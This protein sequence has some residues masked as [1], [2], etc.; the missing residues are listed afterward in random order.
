MSRNASVALS[1]EVEAPGVELY[2][3]PGVVSQTSWTP[4]EG[5][6]FERWARSIRFGYRLR[7]AAMWWI[8]DGLNWGEE[9]F[10]EQYAQVMD[11]TDYE[12]STL[13]NAA[14]VA[15]RVAPQVRRVELSWSHHAEIAA[16]KDA[17]EQ[18]RWLTLAIEGSWTSK[19]LRERVAS[20]RAGDTQSA[21]GTAHEGHA[22][23]AGRTPPARP[24]LSD[25][26]ERASRQAFIEWVEE[27]GPK[28][29]LDHFGS[30]PD[31]REAVRGRLAQ[32]TSELV[33]SEW[34]ARA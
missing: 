10:G 3:L 5:L 2:G 28:G 20:A 32:R 21:S 24:D 6:D 18:A 12:Y 31:Y 16:C 8:G 11:A 4:P 27:D 19:E 15:R 17:D 34:T 26:V 1:S 9:R 22:T 13:A 25:L 14:S 33:L 30:H 29:M 7:G 23:P